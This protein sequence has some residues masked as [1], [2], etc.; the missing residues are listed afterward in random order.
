MIEEFLIPNRDTVFSTIY[1]LIAFCCM[2]GISLVFFSRAARKKSNKQL[3]SVKAWA[4]AYPDFQ[5][6]L[7]MS[8]RSKK[9]KSNYTYS[10]RQLNTIFNYY[11]YNI[12]EESEVNDNEIKSCIEHLKAIKN[13]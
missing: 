3:D 12:T 10:Y 9:E 6:D 2:G 13:S 8:I 7:P 11:T 5:L 4:S 1:L